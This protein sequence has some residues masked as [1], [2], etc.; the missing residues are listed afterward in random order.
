L[1]AIR[2]QHKDAGRHQNS[3]LNVLANVL[4]LGSLV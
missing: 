1:T 3:P 4:H 2:H